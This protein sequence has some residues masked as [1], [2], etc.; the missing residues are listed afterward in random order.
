[1]SGN[2]PEKIGNRGIIPVTKALRSPVKSA[3]SRS[4]HQEKHPVERTDR[5]KVLERTIPGTENNPENEDRLPERHHDTGKP[6]Y[7][8]DPRLLKTVKKR[9]I[10]AT[11]GSCMT[12][13]A[14]RN[15]PRI[16]AFFNANSGTSAAKAGSSDGGQAKL[17]GHCFLLKRLEPFPAR[18]C[19][20]VPQAC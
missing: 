12:T 6:A 5:K 11:L 2:A 17:C 7:K 10:L 8:P 18:E 19:S 15:F 4:K 9:A 14:T 13:R 20:S 3:D 16:S 1:M